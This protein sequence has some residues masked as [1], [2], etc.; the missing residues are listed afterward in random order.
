[1]DFRTIDASDLLKVVDAICEVELSDNFKQTF[2]T[3]RRGRNAIQHLGKYHSQIDPLAILDVLVMHYQELYPDR[4]WLP[5]C[6]DFLA[7]DVGGMFDDNRHFNS[8]TRALLIVGQMR[9]FLTKRQVRQL[10]CF[11][12]TSRL[13][14]CYDCVR[15][16]DYDNRGED[17]NTL[18]W[19]K[20]APKAHCHLCETDFQIE[21]KLCKFRKSD[22]FFA[23]GGVAASAG[24]TRI[25]KST[26][27]A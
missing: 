18:T 24:A 1:M 4:L 17:V 14:E 12:E 23:E 15:N 21:R 20:D 3:I 13:F 19:E 22:V 26:G 8:M 7:S 5:D 25:T 9:E 11:S 16:A 27:L 10:F 6:L 2:E